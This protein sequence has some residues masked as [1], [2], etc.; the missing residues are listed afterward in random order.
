MDKSK[1]SIVSFIFFIIISVNGAHGLELLDFLVEDTA[2]G[3]DLIFELFVNNTDYAYADS[4][5]IIEL[6]NAEPV[7]TLSEKF[8][9]PPYRSKLLTSSYNSGSLE[10]GS[11]KAIV[12]VECCGEETKR[13]SKN[14]RILEYAE[15]LEI[16]EMEAEPVS[17][18]ELLVINLK[19]RNVGT[20][21]LSYNIVLEISDEYDNKINEVSFKGDIKKQTEEEVQSAWK[22]Y[23][24]QMG[25]YEVTAG[26]YVIKAEV[27][28]G[29]KGGALDK[30]LSR[31]VETELK[32]NKYSAYLVLFIIL[33]PV[34]LLCRKK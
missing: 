9:L 17:V 14:F 6:S 22:T 34:I 8:V 4:T 2:K 3:E 20:V 26:D 23:E 18:G 29:K 7:D 12:R 13:I 24:R 1:F 19:L 32:E 31:S 11:Y 10:Y 25:N 15:K 16:K 27:K 30:T 33:V 5:V 21:D 28:Y